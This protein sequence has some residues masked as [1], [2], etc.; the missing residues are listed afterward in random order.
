M[1]KSDNSIT[2]CSNCDNCIDCCER[3]LVCEN[4][5]LSRIEI[6]MAKIGGAGTDS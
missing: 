6:F 4:F 2:V 1:K 3:D 5:H